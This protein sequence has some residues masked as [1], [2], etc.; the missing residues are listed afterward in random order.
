MIGLIG[1]EESQ[2]VTKAFREKGHEFYSCDRE[3]CSGG[4]PEWHLQMDI[5]KA[6]TLRKWDFIGLHL[7]CTKMT[8]SGNR[9][10]APIGFS[11]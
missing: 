1:F 6:L 5:Y 2:E 4:H 9:H 3:D 10:Y 11:I 7:T 8:L